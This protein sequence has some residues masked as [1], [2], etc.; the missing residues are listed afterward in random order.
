MALARRGNEEA[1]ILGIGLDET[2]DELAADFVGVLAD[3]GAYGGDDAASPGALS[4]AIV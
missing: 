4:F 2:L 1:P 3:Q